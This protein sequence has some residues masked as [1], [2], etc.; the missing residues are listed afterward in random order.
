LNYRATP[1]EIREKV[2]FV[3]SEIQK[4]LTGLAALSAVQEGLILSTCNRVEL[5]ATTNEIE[6]GTAQ[7]K[8]FVADFHAVEVEDISSYFYTY[9]GQNAVRHLF[10]VA[11]SLD[12]M[13]VGEPQILGQ[14]KTAYSQACMARTNALI[15]NRLMH[16]TF[17]VAKRVRNETLISNKAVSIPFAAV[18]MVQRIFG[19]LKGKKVLLIGSGKIGELAA[20]HFL[21][22]GVGSIS[23][24]NRTLEQAERLAKKFQGQAI[25][26]EKL[27]EQ[28]AVADIVLSTTAAPHFIIR[29]QDVEKVIRRRKGRPLFLVDIAV[30]RDVDPE[31]G[32]I[33][34]VYLYDVD[35]LQGI[36]SSNLHSRRQEADK[37]EAIIETEVRKFL[38][39]FH[40]LEIVPT[41]ASLRKKV[42]GICR[43]EVAKMYGALPNTESDNGEAIDAITSAMVKKILHQPIRALKASRNQRSGH[44]YAEALRYLFALEALE[45]LNGT[46]S[47]DD[48]DDD[49]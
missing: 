40:N 41:I 4:A 13:V 7:I 21:N 1:V 2:A 31:V 22:S 27:H 18:E 28:L 9:S 6:D 20:S 5:Y 26:L 36:I 38:N 23:L 34:D 16:R 35:D 39:W 10:R 42:E 8:K 11:S 47:R 45:D 24:I 15:L 46:G 44:Y 25:P 17:S 3:P 49:C 32:N 30:P 12:S 33:P 29:P 19:G 37:A 14:V 48:F 43:K